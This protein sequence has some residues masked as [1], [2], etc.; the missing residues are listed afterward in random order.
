MKL[1]ALIAALFVTTAAPAIAQT[2]PAPAVPAAPAAPAATA[3]AAKFDLDTPI[4]TIAADPAGKAVL[5]ADF[6]GMLAHPAYE[7]FKVLSLSAVQP[8]SNGALTDAQL[9]KAKVDLAALK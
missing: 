5:E 4:A 3:P 1:A 6:P 2:A 9:A 8:L 7:Q